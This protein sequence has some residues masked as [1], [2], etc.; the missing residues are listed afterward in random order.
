[1]KMADIKSYRNNISKRN[2]WRLFNLVCTYVTGLSPVPW[3]CSWRAVLPSCSHPSHTELI[4]LYSQRP[5]IMEENATED[6][7]FTE[8]YKCPN[9]DRK[10]KE[11]R[12]LKR[13]VLYR[14]KALTPPQILD[15]PRIAPLA[16]TKVTHN[17]ELDDRLATIGSQYARWRLSQVL[18][19]TQTQTYP[20]LFKYQYRGSRS[21]VVSKCCPTSD[22]YVTMYDVLVDARDNHNV[23]SIE[24]P[25]SVVVIDEESETDVSSF[26]LPTR[27][28]SR[29]NRPMFK[30]E[31]TA[32]SYVYSLVGNIPDTGLE[33]SLGEMTLAD[34][35]DE[36]DLSVSSAGFEPRYEQYNYEELHFSIN[37]LIYYLLLWSLQPYIVI[38]MKIVVLLQ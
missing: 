36:A 19:V 4:N 35:C 9:C 10:F 17:N 38:F 7:G 23:D 29:S 3:P 33:T 21:S 31:E 2:P 28:V 5:S 11:E 20:I 34:G 32:T 22:P 27:E 37:T 15:S 26:L 8:V 13:H 12:T 18:G 24:M 6:S 14:C 1:M 25:K 30:T 16:V